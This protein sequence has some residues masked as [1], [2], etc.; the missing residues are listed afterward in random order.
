MTYQGVL[1]PNHKAWVLIL[2]LSQ[3]DKGGRISGPGLWPQAHP[4][5][6]ASSTG[7]D[8]SSQGS[9]CHLPELPTVAPRKGA[10]PAACG[11]AHSLCQAGPPHHSWPKQCLSIP[12]TTQAPKQD[13]WIV[14]DRHQ[15]PSQNYWLWASEEAAEIQ[16]QNSWSA[17][18]NCQV[19]RPNPWTPEQDTWT[20]EWNS[21]TLSWTF[22]QGPRSPGHSSRN[23]RHGLPATLP[24]AWIFSFP[25]PSSYWTILTL[26]FFTH[27]AHPH[28]PAPT[29]S[30]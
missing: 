27:L 9:Q 28:G 24:P 29:P 20:L 4:L 5:P 14:G 17:E 2:Y 22:T 3:V 16:S 26:L 10:F 6:S 21:W 15:C 23:F 8:H 1:P 12:H 25:K 11:G 30:S 7:Q 18:P 19:P 13:F